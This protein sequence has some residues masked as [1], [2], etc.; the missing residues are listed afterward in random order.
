MTNHRQNS[1]LPKPDI[2]APFP[3]AWQTIPC[4]HSS[5]GSTRD[6]PRTIRSAQGPYLP[7]M[8]EV[9]VKAVFGCQNPDHILVGSEIYGG[10][11]LST[12]WNASIMHRPYR[13]FVAAAAK[14]TKID[15]TYSARASF[16]EVFGTLMDWNQNESATAAD[17]L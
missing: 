5:R 16:I 3:A 1:S 9:V 6:M 12:V 4:R 2:Y 8:V 7:E 11:L 14:L 17:H 13:P 15:A 10:P